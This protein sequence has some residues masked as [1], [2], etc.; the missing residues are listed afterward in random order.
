MRQ[1][2][3]LKN[4]SLLGIALF[5]IILG[6]NITP[7]TTHATN[8]AQLERQFLMECEDKGCDDEEPKCVQKTGYYSCLATPSES[9]CSAWTCSGDPGEG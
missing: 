6:L 1:L 9:T 8:G 7:Q 3:Y 2:K 4:K 5:A